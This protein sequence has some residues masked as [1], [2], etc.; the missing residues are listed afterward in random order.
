MKKAVFS[1]VHEA[2]IAT[3]N[4]LRLF[5]TGCLIMLGT[6]SIGF[7]FEREMFAGIMFYIQQKTLPPFGEFYPYQ[8]LLTILFAFGLP[9]GM[10]FMMIFT[11]RRT[12]LHPLKRRRL[13][14]ASVIVFFLAILVPA[15]F[16]RQS[17]KWFFGIGGFAIM[18]GI[19]TSFWYFSR[20]Y[21]AANAR[22]R[23]AFHFRVL[24]YLCFGMVTWHICGFANAPGFAMFPEKMMEMNV[25]PFAI[26]QLKSIMAYLVFGWLFTA[27]GHYQSFSQKEKSAP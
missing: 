17:S 7:F 8:L 21:P 14:L 16:G 24:G 3:G 10:V 13:I 15:L 9:L 11:V 27:L 6:V 4:S 20:T 26:G 18:A 22:I 25:Q 2:V 19:A 5:V 23:S 12:E 1:P